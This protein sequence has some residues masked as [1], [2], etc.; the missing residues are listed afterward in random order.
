[1]KKT[2][3]P[4]IL[5]A[6]CIPF[7]VNAE[8]NISPLCDIC[9]EK[10]IREYYVDNLKIGQELNTGDVL[11]LDTPIDKLLDDEDIIANLYP[12]NENDPWIPGKSLYI[13]FY[14]DGENK[15]FVNRKI[16][17]GGY[18]FSN[19]YSSFYSIIDF[20]KNKYWKLDKVEKIAGG[21]GAAFYFKSYNRTVNLNII[22]TVNDID[23]YNA[24]KDEILMYSVKIQNTGD[25]YSEN[26]IISTT[27]PTGLEI[28]KDRISDNGIYNEEDNTI[29]WNLDI[30]N[31]NEEYT[32]YYYA[33]VID[34]DIKEYIGHSYL[35]SNQV[36]EQIESENTIVNIED[37]IENPYT[38]DKLYLVIL[39]AVISMGLTTFIYKRK[40]F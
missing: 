22:N 13:S 19:Y 32:F 31:P 14:F 25:G 38:G 24:K 20:N 34:S 4:I 37:T 35:T 39:F 28:D 1:M 3:L 10:G 12:Y 33:K 29:T 36:Q 2:I 18:T 11:Y 7:V 16:I 8:S 27:I 40:G 5:F 23:K 21:E 26:N 15:S 6:I 30:L 9:N 17:V